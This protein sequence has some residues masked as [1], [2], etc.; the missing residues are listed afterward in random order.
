MRVILRRT[1]S[2]GGL[3]V[4]TDE[5]VDL[6]RIR[7]GRGTDQDVQLAD[8]R[9]TLAHA[10]IRLQGGDWRIECRSENPVWINGRQ[11]TEG[12]V[13]PG[14]AMNFGRFRVHVRNPPPGVGLLLEIEEHLSARQVEAA[15]KARVRVTLGDG[16]L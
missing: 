8:M 1:E 5:E 4:A 2:L 7:I 6:D 3:A 16:G 11:V 13:K 10:E 14:D 9:V 12:L 15:R